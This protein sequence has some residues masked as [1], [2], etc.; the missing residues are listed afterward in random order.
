ML[1]N[2]NTTPTGEKLKV[3]FHLHGKLQNQLMEL[4][5]NMLFAVLL[6]IKGHLSQMK[7]EDR[8]AMPTIP[9]L[10]RCKFQNSHNF[11]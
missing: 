4:A 2:G 6:Y 5:M 7:I 3:N 1:T 10:P 11:D 9:T 8:V